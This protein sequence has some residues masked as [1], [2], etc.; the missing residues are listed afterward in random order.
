MSARNYQKI[1]RGS[2]RIGFVVSHKHILKRPCRGLPSRILVMCSNLKLSIH[3]LAKFEVLP[4][5]KFWIYH[6]LTQSYNTH[7]GTIEEEILSDANTFSRVQVVNILT[8]V[9]TPCIYMGLSC[10]RHLFAYYSRHFQHRFRV[11][12][13]TMMT[14]QVINKLLSIAS[15]IN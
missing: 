8:R 6:T 4:L 13:R 2:R 15:E 5:T 14:I 11:L 9:T 1:H 3:N 12:Y 7:K 10:C